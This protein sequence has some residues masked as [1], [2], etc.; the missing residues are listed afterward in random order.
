MIFALA[1]ASATPDSALCQSYANLK[2][3]TDYPLI[4]KSGLLCQD[5]YLSCD[6]SISGQLTIECK[7]YLQSGD[8]ITVLKYAGTDFYVSPGISKI[9]VKYAADDSN[10][11]VS[12]PYYE[13]LKRTGDIA[14]GQYRTRIHIEDINAHWSFDYTFMQAPDSLLSGASSLRS[15]INKSLAPNAGPLTPLKKRLEKVAGYASGKAIKN[16]RK[17]LDDVSRS[18]GL[19]RLEYQKGSKTYIDYYFEDWFAGRYEASNNKKLSKQLLQEN[20]VT[21]AINVNKLATNDIDAH[22]SLFSQFR[23]FKRQKDDNQEIK[24]EIAIAGNTATSQEPNSGV[25]NNYY[26]IRG[27]VELPIMQLPFE[28]EGLYTSQDAHRQVKTSFVHVHYDVDKMKSELMQFVGSYNQK[29]AE[30]KSKTAGLEQVYAKGIQTLEARKAKLEKELAGQFTDAKSTGML[31]DAEN[32]SGLVDTSGA[33]GVVPGDMGEQKKNALDEERKIAEKRK[34]LEV[35]KKEL[36][37]LDK[38]IEKYRLLLEQN[39][40]TNYFDSAVG[41]SRTAGFNGSNASYKQLAKRSEGLLP[42]GNAKSFISGFSS[43]DAGMFPKYASKYTMSGQVMKGVDMAYDL[44]LCEVGVSAGKTEYVGRDGSPDKY[45]CYSLKTKFRVAPSQDVSLIYYGYSPD[46]KLYGGDAF[47]RNTD[48]ATPTFFHPVH[49]VSLNYSG[50]VSDYVIINSEAASA[51]RSADAHTNTDMKELMGLH[52]DAAGA[53]P[54]TPVQLQASFDKT[55]KDFENSTLPVTLKGTEQYRL[56]GTTDL[57]HNFLSLGLDYYYLSQSSLTYS[58]SNTRWGIDI[59]THSKRYP[60]VSLSYKPFSTFKTLN[61]TFSI[62][63]RPMFG[64][65]LTSR[66]SYQFKRNGNVWR[67]S[68]VYNKSTTTQDTS[69]YG[70]TMLQAI[71]IYTNKMLTVTSATG[72][73]EQH[74]TSQTMAA[75]SM[76]FLNAGINYFFSKEVGISSGIETGVTGFGFCKYAVAGGISISPKKKPVTVRVNLR[77]AGYRQQRADTWKPLYNGYMELAYR[78]RHKLNKGK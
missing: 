65:V 6:S 25:D 72:Y 75:P 17:K 24:G 10:A 48:I 11:F 73:M 27:Q 36:E 23:K 46:R 15:D 32:P 62:P 43:F 7:K 38:K 34:E 22:P 30:T 14:P 26:E 49:I 39:R 59:R 54:G 55:G 60:S 68:L 37:A 2:A 40:N 3:H 67:F 52:L 12:R 57:F 33:A 18:R 78:F 44:G 50:K 66:A 5:V 20:D 21:S 61:D 9:T 41:Y 64:S 63:Q 28:I 8:S 69:F 19:T 35:K 53:V 13:I 47:F 16:A 29:F 77:A 1:L 51:I 74:G 76:S 56:G 31:K 71:C 4:R 58:G 70:N 45:T 42:D